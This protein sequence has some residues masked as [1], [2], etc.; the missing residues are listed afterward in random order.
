VPGIGKSAICHELA[1]SDLDNVSPHSR[2][3][4][5]RHAAL[6]S[7]ESCVEFVVQLH[8]AVRTHLCPQWPADLSRPR[9]RARIAKN[10]VS[11]LIESILR[12]L[13]QQH[14]VQS[15]RWCVIIDA[16]DACDPVARLL[17]DKSVRTSMP[18]WLRLIATSRPGPLCGE[19]RNGAHTIDLTAQRRENL[20]D[21]RAFV[22]DSITSLRASERLDVKDWDRL[23]ETVV[24]TSA[25]SFLVAKLTLADVVRRGPVPA[26]TFPVSLYQEFDRWFRPIQDSADWYWVQPLL[27]LLVRRPCD[28]D[29]DE[30]EACYRMGGPDFSGDRF[31]TALGLL[32]PFL[33]PSPDQLDVL[34]PF[35]PA[36]TEWLQR[37]HKGESRADGCQGALLEVCARLCAIHAQH[38]CRDVSKLPRYLEKFVGLRHVPKR[39][40]VPG[41]WRRLDLFAAWHTLAATLE[42]STILPDVQFELL[43]SVISDCGLDVNQINLFYRCNSSSAIEFFLRCG[44]FAVDHQDWNGQT[45]LHKA[46]ATGDD[47]LVRFL[48][49]VHH[50]SVSTRDWQGRTPLHA[51]AAGSF[52]DTVL[53]FLLDR[54]DA[55]VR[56]AQVHA[57]DDSGLN[58]FHVASERKERGPECYRSVQRLCELGLSL[59]DPDPQGR[60][61]LHSAVSCRNLDFVKFLVATAASDAQGLAAFLALKEELLVLA[62]CDCPVVFF[63]L[64]EA[65]RALWPVDDRLQVCLPC[66][67]CVAC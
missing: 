35:H 21:L 60:T 23:Q 46:A 38:S 48:V 45:L 12:P 55:Q 52:D 25:G 51:C 9:D 3:L 40:V 44:R 50:A 16:L 41:T 22:S 30:L 20:D 42:T 61:L 32:R 59:T 1:Q 14:P 65:P 29:T 36:F 66:E 57:L 11:G 56:V 49:D 10:P 6:S 2:L 64:S 54:K 24:S 62:S 27:H 31:A 43:H 8:Q 17:L 7:S 13:Q 33:C 19:L 63:L 53:G 37:E 34:S 18:P 26:D 28:L 5:H 15:T 39:I 47:G 58:L 67:F 4:Y